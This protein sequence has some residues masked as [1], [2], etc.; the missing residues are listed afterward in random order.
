MVNRLRFLAISFVA[1]CLYMYNKFDV[2]RPIHRYVT[3][4]SRRFDCVK[5]FHK[6]FRKSVSQ[7]LDNGLERL[8]CQRKLKE[9]PGSN[10]Q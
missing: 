6:A 10:Q 8:S 3:I 1:K 5:F 4:N 7:Q 2:C 9:G